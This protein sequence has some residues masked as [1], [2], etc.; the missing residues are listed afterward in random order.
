MQSSGSLNCSAFD[1]DKKTKQVIKGHYVCAGSQ[2]KP[3]GAG[4]SA[5]GSSKPSSSG[6]SAAGH[7]EINMSMVVVPVLVGSISLFAGLFRLI[8]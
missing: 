3:G 7:I 4:T 6:K 2:T 5:S 8:M 1:A